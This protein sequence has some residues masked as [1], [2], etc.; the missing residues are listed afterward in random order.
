[1]RGKPAKPATKQKTERSVAAIALAAVLGDGYSL[2]TALED[3]PKQLAE[4]RQRA[5]CQA[6]CYGVMRYL[7]YL[8]AILEQLLRHPIKKRD[9]DIQAL[10]LSGLYQHLYMQVPPHAATAATVQAAYE[11]GKG[12]AAGLINAVLR[13][14]A[15]RRETLLQTL[16]NGNQAAVYAHPPWLF[17]KIRKD[18]SQHWQ[19]IMEEANRQAP[20]S[21]RVNRQ[22]ITRS[23]YLQMLRDHGM[24]AKEGDFGADTLRLEQ[25]KAVEALPGFAQGLVS[26]QDEA[27]QLAVDLLNLDDTGLT[28]NIRVLDA[29]AA[30]GGKAAHIL[31]RRPDVHL[32]ALEREPARIPRLENTLQR[33]QLNAKIHC[34]DASLPGTWWDGGAFD[35]VL[36]DAPCSGSGVIRRHPDIKYLRRASDIDT[37]AQD[38]K[39]LLDTCW[40][41]LKRGGLL[42]YATCSILTQ[43]NQRQV[44]AFLQRH[45]DA[46]DKS[47]EIQWGHRM[48]P[49]LQILPG[50]H[51][52]DGFYYACLEKV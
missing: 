43:E 7:P 35:R 17:E 47:P 39:I 21:L 12:R 27:A 11:L 20:M 2:D 9:S 18:W 19:A 30:P 50:E 46:T 3:L 34:G 38:Q 41:L 6:L 40:S 24:E 23:A 44:A 49:G 14:F 31:E 33:L 1:M 37:L 8:Q 15:R 22:K 52:M 42:L 28:A 25:A 29:C 51:Y 16:E 45:P 26:V 5:F 36:L 4:P 10:L 48:E 32:L 13:N